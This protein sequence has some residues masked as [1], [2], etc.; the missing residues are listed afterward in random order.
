MACSRVSGRGAGSRRRVCW[1]GMNFR[2][3]CKNWQ[4]ESER[5]CSWT[6]SCGE[7]RH[8]AS[9]HLKGRPCEWQTSGEEDACTASKRR[10]TPGGSLVLR[11]AQSSPSHIGIFSSLTSSSSRIMVHATRPPAPF[12]LIVLASS[13]LARTEAPR[14]PAP[15]APPAAAGTSTPE[16]MCSS[17]PPQR[18]QRAYLRLSGADW[19][20]LILLVVAAAALAAVH[21]L[22]R[23]LEK[24]L[25]RGMSRA[26]AAERAH[27][28]EY[29]DGAR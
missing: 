15:L 18:H 2:L 23:A 16:H 6:G 12:L 14:R 7:L 5:C 25:E 27:G 3:R 24:L 9:A 26:E 8:S 4:P 1:G 20:V 29:V 21:L 13:V 10:R 17:M 28:R 19:G 22:A 11:P